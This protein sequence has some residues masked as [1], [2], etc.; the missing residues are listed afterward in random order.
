MPAPSPIS[1][2]GRYGTCGPS[3][4]PV[5]PT[6]WPLRKRCERTAGWRGGVWRNRSNEPAMPL[7][8]LQSQILRLL[9]AGRSPDSYIAV[10][11]AV[12]RS[13]PRFS[14]DIDIFQDSEQRLDAAATA[15]EETLREAG[16]SV[17][18]KKI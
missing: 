5:L 17:S 12:N 6:P 1:A 15:D 13:G 18:W 2:H 14:G 3:K 11:V 10:G 8:R 7:T 9:A 16:F 4:H